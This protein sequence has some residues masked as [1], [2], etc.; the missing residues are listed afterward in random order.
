MLC[1][2]ISII[3]SSH[4]ALAN[5]ELTGEEI[6]KLFMMEKGVAIEVNKKDENYQLFL[7]DIL[8]G[9]Y[10]ELTGKH[11][12]FLTSQSELNLVLEHA[13]K[14]LSSVFHDFPEEPEAQEAIIGEKTVDSRKVLLTT[15]NRTDAID[16]AYTWWD[17]RSPHYPDFGDSDC[18]NFISQAM[19][20]GGFSKVG[21]GDGCRDENT[22]TEFY[23]YSASPPFW[24][25][26]SNRS[27]EWS[28]S[29][30]VV[31]PF[32]DYFAHKNNYATELG[33]T[34]SASTAMHLLSPGDIVQL[35]NK[36]GDNWISYHNMLVTDTDSN[37]LLLTYHARNRKDKP[38]SS[39]PT[40]STQRYMLIKF[41]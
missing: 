41:P 38:L 22:H 18:T 31:W 34:T 37:D 26:G 14:E 7:K 25:L 16:Y 13:S 40:G 23:S 30:S 1:I 29:W 3:T 12:I 20:A 19:L 5:S 33:W 27:W 32:R 15:Y 36:Q 11:S 9:E 6:I 35:Q 10:P 2:I 17:S 28:T 24:C 4:I 21:S 39:I 8:L